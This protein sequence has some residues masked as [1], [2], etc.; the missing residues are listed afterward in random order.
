MRNQRARMYGSADTIKATESMRENTKCFPEKQKASVKKTIFFWLPY[1]I[2]VIIGALLYDVHAQ[3]EG[4]WMF[5]IRAYLSDLIN[6]QAAQLLTNQLCIQLMQ[7]LLV[8]FLA[9]S[10]LGYPIIFGCCLC[11][12]AVH[13][14]IFCLFCSQQMNVMFRDFLTCFIAFEFGCTAIYLYVIYDAGRLSK[15]LFGINALK[16]NKQISLRAFWERFLVLT[17]L[18]CL[19]C[20]LVWGLSLMGPLV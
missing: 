19:W 3:Q 20:I 7:L 8:A 4:F 15:R 18:S 17:L 9:H 11:R 16:E 6:V 2:G 14:S 1:G 12:A 10:V 5:F 13:A